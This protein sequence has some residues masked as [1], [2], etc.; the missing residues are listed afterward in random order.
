MARFALIITF[1]ALSGALAATAEVTLDTPITELIDVHLRDE[2]AR[3]LSV[4]DREAFYQTYEDMYAGLGDF[5]LK[6][7]RLQVVDS[8][9]FSF[10]FV[11][12]SLMFCN[13]LGSKLVDR[14]PKGRQCYLPLVCKHN[15]VGQTAVEDA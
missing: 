6:E 13:L 3:V 12:T 10:Q 1:V 5:N 15:E 4:E 9:S 7:V 2:I 11:I 14:P 8:N